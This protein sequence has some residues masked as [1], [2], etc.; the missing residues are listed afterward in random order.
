MPSRVKN[1]NFFIGLLNYYF[2]CCIW[3][4]V[5]FPFILR[6]KFFGLNKFLT[7]LLLLVLTISCSKKDNVD[8]ITELSSILISNT[9]NIGKW[10]LTALKYGTTNLVLT[11]TQLLFTKHYAKDYK[12]SDTD[13]LVGTWSMPTANQLVEV[14]TNF[15]SG[16]SVTQE[17]KIISITPTQLTLYHIVNGTEITAIYSASM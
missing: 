15:S 14:I 1:C 11:P 4:I 7:I 2:F 9:S 12:Y 3:K 5:P 17:Y 6:L 13:G 10:R 8:P 16:I